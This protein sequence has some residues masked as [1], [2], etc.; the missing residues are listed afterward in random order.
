MH[1]PASI[2]QV[3]CRGCGRSPTYRHPLRPRTD[4]GCI[5]FANRPGIMESCLLA[6][7]TSSYGPGA[8]SVRWGR[9]SACSLSITQVL[10]PHSHSNIRN[11]RLV[12]GSSM[13][14]TNVGCSSHL[15]QRGEIGLG[16]VC[17]SM[18]A[19]SRAQHQERE[20]SG[21]AGEFF[22]RSWTC[23]WAL[24]R[25]RPSPDARNTAQLSR[26]HPVNRNIP[27]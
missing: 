15:E 27:W 10:L 24:A 8:S 22:H 2:R 3:N 5:W 6:R 12:D 23:G 9:F 16:G 7:V 21:S 13:L 26:L 20:D 18:P 4:C 11:L 19:K 1:S 25:S 17:F 14:V